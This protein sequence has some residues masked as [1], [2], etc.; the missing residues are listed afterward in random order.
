VRSQIRT[1][2]VEFGI[3]DEMSGLLVTQRS[4]QNSAKGLRAKYAAGQAI[5]A[6]VGADQFALDAEGGGLQRD[7]NERL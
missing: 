5:R 3:G 1:R 7:E 6:V 4:T 2:T